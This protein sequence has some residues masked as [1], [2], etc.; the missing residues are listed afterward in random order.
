MTG[1]PRVAVV[2][3]GIGGLAAARALL[4]TGRVDVAVFDAAD[5]PGG[6][7][8]SVRDEGYLHE[9]AAN[10]F[11][12]NVADGAVPLCEELG[13]PVEPASPAAKRRWVFYRGRLRPVPASPWEA[14]RTDLVSWRGKLYAA[15]EPLRRPL[16]IGDESVAAFARR[17][18]GPEIAKVAVGPMVTGVFAGD[19][20]RLSLRAAFPKIAALEERGGL[21]RG[22]IATARQR[23]R[24]GQPRRSGRLC[25][26]LGGA[27]ALVDAV[28][29]EVGDALRT[30]ASVDRVD[31]LK[32]GRLRLRGQRLGK[33]AAQPFDAVVLA[34]A[35]PVA[36]ELVAGALPD[37]V[38]PLRGI[39]FAPVAVA[40]LGYRRGDVPH[41][42]DGFGFLVV[43]GEPIRALGVVFESSIWSGRA[44]D[45]CVLLR[46]V[47]G[48]V[49]DPAAVD[50]DDDDLIAAA[51]GDVGRALGI[52][53]APTHR[54]VFRHRRAI[55]QYTIGHL[56]RVTAAERVCEPAGVVLA[57][58]S[59]HGVAVNACVADASRV[60]RRVLAHVGVA[61]CA[62]IAAACAAGGPAPARPAVAPADA[63]VS[64]APAA[65]RGADP[66]RTAPPGAVEVQV[67]W[68]RPSAEMLRSPG[69]NACGAP[70]PAPLPVAP[71]AVIAD[72]HARE[73]TVGVAGAVVTAAGPAPAPPAPPAPP[74]AVAV[75]DCTLSPRV[76]LVPAGGAVAVI[77]DDDRRHVVHV[78]YAGGGAA[79]VAPL[80]IAGR[81]IDV[82]LPREGIAALW[83]E[84]DPDDVV[85][86]A[87]AAHAWTA[88]TDAAGTARLDG[89]PP[90][91]YE[92]RV[93][94]PP[95]AP[96]GPDH[97]AV[98]RA[99]VP[100]ESRVV[101]ALEGGPR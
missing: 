3:A 30:G 35:A 101:I 97:T 13:V 24:S 17:R 45:D 29:A 86:V 4:H 90:G 38:R 31:R 19:A 64:R 52:A 69:V 68:P 47:Y 40:Y 53:A 84:A 1:R 20:E 59:Y 5:R 16:R 21:V 44:P 75:R 23:R 22:M 65:E 62:A 51:R 41:P 76:A 87:V 56:D 71:E 27:G 80:P 43:D 74:A 98:A 6:V 73:R 91:R 94:F 79:V 14:L 34:V 54:A 55:A 78:R 18:L 57:G 81:R 25:A 100:A 92:L 39:E 88:I 93:W 9:R 63:A 49:R 11:L 95:A 83:T 99:D 70:R 96:G 89:L 7:I 82:P 42:L 37:A 15:A 28:A 77:N 61:A 50:L 58:A 2:G 12:D 33:A 26:P 32:N 8:R 72:R 10:G 36:A 46:C 67:V 60:A 48:G 85:Y 66:A